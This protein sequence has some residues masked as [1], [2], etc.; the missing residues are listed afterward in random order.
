MPAHIQFCPIELPGHGTRFSEPLLDTVDRLIPRLIR[1]ILPIL[2]RP[3][4]V[5]GHSLGALL[6]FE[7]CRHLVERQGVV[8]NRLF[9]SGRR[10]PHAISPPPL[11]HTLSDRDLID[12]VTELG[13]IP[14]ELA[15][16]EDLMS[17]MLPIL[18]ADFRMTERYEN[19]VPPP[20]PLPVT[21]ITGNNDPEVSVQEMQDWQETSAISFS[22]HPLDGDH[23]Y[24][25]RSDTR[26][27]LILLICQH[28]NMPDLFWKLLI[29]ARN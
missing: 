4:F 6:A 27:K 9:V 29:L 21:A 17:L 3:F 10:A 20:L 26:R 2:D 11:R 25:S 15:G 7:L 8:P 14:D 12:N 13:G 23:F 22:L 24:F 5:F 18:R 19:T 16:S 1:D 28:I